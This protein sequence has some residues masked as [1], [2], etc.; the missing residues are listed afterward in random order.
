[1]HKITE[2]ILAEIDALVQARDLKDDEVARELN[3]IIGH[4]QAHLAMY[5][6]NAAGDV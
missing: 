2:R 1:M 4:A 5:E 3:D 6:S